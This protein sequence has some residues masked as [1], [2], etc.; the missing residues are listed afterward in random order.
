MKIKELAHRTESV[1][2]LMR[3]RQMVPNSEIVSIL[4]LAF[5]KLRDLM[6]NY[7][8]SNNEDISE[9]TAAL[10]RSLKSI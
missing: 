5:D 1:L 2:D 6:A 8:D 4:L 9:F 3:S 7:S 10:S